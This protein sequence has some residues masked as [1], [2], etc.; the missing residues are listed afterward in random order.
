MKIEVLGDS[1]LAQTLKRAAVLRGFVVDS[2]V[3]E[4]E[5]TFV[6]EDVYDHANVQEV[7]TWMPYAIDKTHGEHPVIVISQVP[8]GWTR[9]WSATVRDVFYQVDTII[10]NTALDRMVYPE[11]FVIGCLD[12]EKPLPLAYQEFLIGFAAPILKMNYE[13]AELVKL[14]INYFLTAQINTTNTL[15]AVAKAIG[16]DWEQVK[17]G[18][19]NDKRI[20]KYAYLRPGQPN[21][22]LNRDV[23]TITKIKEDGDG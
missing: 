19:Q 4:V 10:M 7:D 20:G 16:A 22:H 14:G 2:P 9:K 21:I 8:P 5:L 12:P 13:S 15:A 11:Q 18:L 3:S 1:H 6:A 17:K 23:A